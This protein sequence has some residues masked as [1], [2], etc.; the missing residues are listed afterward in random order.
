MAARGR[1][2]MTEVDAS[3]LNNV[4]RLILCQAVYEYGS[5][6]WPE[7][8][9]VLSTHPIILRPKLFNAQV[10]NSHF[11]VVRLAEVALVSRR[12]L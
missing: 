11:A 3:S 1:G 6:S 10:S 5:D 8:A 9:R 4:E 2:K 7:V 12:V